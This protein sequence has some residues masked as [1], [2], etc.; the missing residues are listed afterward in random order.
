M[1]EQYLGKL[2]DLSVSFGQLVAL[3]ELAENMVGN[4]MFGNVTEDKKK[5]KE[6]LQRLLAL[7]QCLAELAHARDQELVKLIQEFNNA[8][9]DAPSQFAED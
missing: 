6:H 1:K 4:Y 2:D 9:Q 3:I 7:L 5:A 8:D